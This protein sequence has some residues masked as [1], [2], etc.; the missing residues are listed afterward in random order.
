MM[1]YSEQKGPKPLGQKPEFLVHYWATSKANWANGPLVTMFKDALG[2][3]QIA[4]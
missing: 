2:V 3:N 1:K 4:T